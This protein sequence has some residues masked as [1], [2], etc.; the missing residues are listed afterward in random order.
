MKTKDRRRCR[1]DPPV[2]GARFSNHRRTRGRQCTPFSPSSQPSKAGQEQLQN[3]DHSRRSALGG[4]R[5]SSGIRWQRLC[6]VS[7]SIPV[8]SDLEEGPKNDV[9]G[10][11]ILVWNFMPAIRHAVIYDQQL[12]G[13]DLNEITCNVCSSHSRLD[14]SANGLSRCR[15]R[16]A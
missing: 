1:F 4:H 7:A 11:A 15:E 16:S 3:L 13:L 10:I 14:E 8:F 5:D 9:L 12:A 2:S 6:L